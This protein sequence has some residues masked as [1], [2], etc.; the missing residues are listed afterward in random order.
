MFARIIYKQFKRK[1]MINTL[2]F[3]TMVALVS[4]YTFILNTNSFSSRSM[5][6][7]MKN[8]GLNQFIIPASEAATKVYLCADDQEEFSEGIVDALATHTDLL[9]KYYLAVLQKKVKL[10]GQ[11]FFMTGIRP[12][13]RS[14]ETKEKKHP[15]KPVDMGT[16]RIGFA[17]SDALGLASGD[18]ID[19]H[20]ES[21]AVA[22][23]VPNKGTMQDYRIFMNLRDTQRLLG[24]A[25]L[26]NVIRSFECLHVGG[27]L[28]EIH[29]FQKKKLAELLPGYKQVNVDNIAKGRY[30]ARIMTDKY[31]YYLLGIVA[32]I[33]ILVF[34]ITG[35][36]EVV[37]RKYETGVLIAQGADYSYIIGLYLCKT[38]ALSVVAAVAG[39][40]IGGSASVL[41]TTPFLT[42]NT[43]TVAIIWSNLPSTIFLICSVAMFAEFIP[44]VKLV[45]MD[46]CVILMEE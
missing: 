27:S 5:K 45:R 17:L 3:L 30:H 13:K 43:A 20:G 37:E 8:M 41:L 44:M 36:Q 21:F 10:D 1:W 32:I 15:I 35:F 42:T 18:K 31:Q 14:D 29:K 38:F 34:I 11:T 7:I 9:S 12:V 16:V 19:L 22:R 25:G 28:D 46:P 23:V 26:I 6:L 39:F 4:L 24:K 2:L 33:T 40:I